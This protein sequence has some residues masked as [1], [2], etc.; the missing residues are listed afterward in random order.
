MTQSIDADVVLT[1][2]EPLVQVTDAHRRAPMHSPSTTS[3]NNGVHQSVP[4]N[5]GV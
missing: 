2:A 5:H 4:V 3:P 1:A